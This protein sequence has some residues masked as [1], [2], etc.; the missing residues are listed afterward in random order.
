MFSIFKLLYIILTNMM[1]V[2]MYIYIVHILQTYKYCIYIKQKLYEISK[3]LSLEFMRL[4]IT[5]KSQTFLAWWSSVLPLSCR[6]GWKCSPPGRS[7]HFTIVG[8]G[9]RDRSSYKCTNYL[10]NINIHKTYQAKV[11]KI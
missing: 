8:R 11:Y 10:L 2:R 4:Q 1:N 3:Q 9:L 5:E 7:F 6:P